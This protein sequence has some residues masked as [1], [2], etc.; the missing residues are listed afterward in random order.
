[1]S[2]SFAEYVRDFLASLPDAEE[3]RRQYREAGYRDILRR[4]GNLVHVA[5]GDEEWIVKVRDE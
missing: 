4:H 3:M 2:D 5:P 1:M